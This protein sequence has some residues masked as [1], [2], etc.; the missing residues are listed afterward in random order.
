MASFFKE[1]YY[2]YHYSSLCSF[3]SIFLIVLILFSILLPFFT[4]IGPLESFWGP[5]KVF[6]DHPIVQFNNEFLI[7]LTY[8]KD[9]SNTFTSYSTSFTQKKTYDQDIILTS[10]SFEAEEYNNK[11]IYSSIKFKAHLCNIT[12]NIYIKSV[13]IYLFFDYYMVEDCLVHIRS[14]VHVPFANAKL[15]GQHIRKIETSGYMNLKQNKPLVNNYFINEEEEQINFDKEAED[16]VNYPLRDTSNQDYYLEFKKYYFIAQITDQTSSTL[17][18]DVSI[19][20]PYYQDIIVALPNYTNLK[21]L[22]VVYSMLFFPT[23]YICYRLMKFVI[24]RQIFKTGIRS[25][26]P[27]KL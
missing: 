24:E 6:T 19:T 22:W 23:L 27:I 16:I 20:I 5:K 13:K 15:D 11:N 26:L 7:A 3:A 12:D 1:N 2:I 14:N 17:D 21:N 25:D 8:V 10:I 9:V 18:I 4:N